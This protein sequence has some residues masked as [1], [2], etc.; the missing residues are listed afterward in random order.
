MKP[1]PESFLRKRA[2]NYLK[3]ADPQKMLSKSQKELISRFKWSARHIP[4]YR[5]LLSEKGISSR[6]IDGLQSFKSSIPVLTKENFFEPYPFEAF[7][8]KGQMDKVDLVTSSSGFSGKMAYGI[9]S[10]QASKKM[11]FG[12]DLTLDL[13]FK[14]SE[15]KTFL[16]N[17]APMGVHVETSAALAETSVRSDMAISLL[18]KVAPSYDQ[19]VIVG[20][21]H[22]LKKLL[23][24]GTEAGID[25]KKLQVS[26]ISGQDWMPESLRTYLASI[27]ELDIEDEKDRGIYLTMGMTELG[28]NVFHE[29]RETVLIRRLCKNDQGMQKQ[30]L[31]TQ[32]PAC[33]VIFHYYPMRTFIEEHANGE[34]LFSILDKDAILPLMRYSTGDMGSVMEYTKI[35]SL[36][37]K[38]HPDLIPKLHLPLG[39]MKGRSKNILG[40]EGKEFQ[41]EMLK[42]GLYEDVE[43][44]HAVTGYFHLEAKN[45]HWQAMIQ[46]KQQIKKNKQLSQKISA[47]F[48]KYTQCDISVSVNSYDEFPYGKELNYE[49][50][51]SCT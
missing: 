18:K 2:I 31:G 44:A 43:A 23:E 28:L 21:P 41:V 46:L 5:K 45:G 8:P 30:I 22:F 35:S 3:K 10:K 25:W 33:P 39:L 36:L 14:A 49:K 6:K 48:L 24:E 12:V 32:T 1:F 50:K 37:S 38:S 34:L 42:E 17:C 29:S 11:R 19:T 40:S 16:I 26:L 15:K 4:A 20:D 27:L 7:I 51:F 13:L 9:V 47:S